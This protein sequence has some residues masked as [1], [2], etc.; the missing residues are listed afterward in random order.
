MKGRPGIPQQFGANQ[1]SNSV[2]PRTGTTMK[3]LPDKV[4][5]NCKAVKDDKSV[6]YLSFAAAHEVGHGLDDERGFMTKNGA[7]ESYGGWITYGSSVQPICDAIVGDPRFAAFC[8]TPEHRKYVLD[9]L[10]NK[11]T[12]PPTGLA[13][14]A[15]AAWVEFNKWYTTATSGD[16]YRRQ[17]DCDYLKIGDRIYHEAYARQWVSY[18][19][20][21]RSKAL[22]GYQ[23]R[24]PGEWFAELYAGFRAKKLKPN[25]PAMSWLSKL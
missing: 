17:G 5:D 10:Q 21:A 1:V 23:F 12:T 16:V 18:L 24:A 9:R 8:A 7:G 20:A 2:S 4:D 6:E 19:A 11:P 13:A 3:E 15:Q 22:T 14:P 25:H